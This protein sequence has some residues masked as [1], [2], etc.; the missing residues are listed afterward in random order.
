MIDVDDSPD[1]GCGGFTGEGKD[2]ARQMLRT[3]RSRRPESS[4]T[5]VGPVVTVAGWTGP[6]SKPDHDSMD[7]RAHYWAA[8]GF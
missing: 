5:I 1:Y 2:M 4:L 3:G 6:L 8:K 7:L